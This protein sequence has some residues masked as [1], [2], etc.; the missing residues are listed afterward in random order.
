MSISNYTLE[1]I[2]HHKEFSNKILRKYYVDGI[3]TIGA[4]GDEPFEIRF[5]NN[6]WNKVQIKLSIDGTDILTGKPAD[7]EISKDMW[8]VNGNSTL[9]LKAWPETSNGGAAFVFTSAEKSVALHTHG[10]LSNRGIIAAAIFIEGYVEPVEYVNNVGH[11][12]IRRRS[13]FDLKD[14]TRRSTDYSAKDSYTYDS[15]SLTDDLIGSTLKSSMES[16][17]AV[18]AGQHVDQKISYVTGLVQPI[19]TE[20]VR[21]KYVWWN[22]L[23]ESLKSINVPT[24]HPSG[25]PGDKKKRNINLKNTPRIATSQTKQIVQQA[26]TRF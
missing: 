16:L 19:F 11:N 7:T 22:D 20:T 4:W 23:V 17:V 3:E 14:I 10:D 2:S 9:S 8:V 18:G 6:S 26:Y 13:V 1:I 24:P 15:F 5:K 12:L 25:F 21:V